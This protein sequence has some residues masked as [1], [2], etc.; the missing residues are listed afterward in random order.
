MWRAEKLFD[1]LYRSIVPTLPV[2]NDAYTEVGQRFNDDQ[3]QWKRKHL[4]DARARKLVAPDKKFRALLICTP[5][6]GMGD[7]IFLKKFVTL[8]S[9]WFPNCILSLMADVQNYDFKDIFDWVHVYD[10]RT[11][12]GDYNESVSLDNAYVHGEH[13]AANDVFFI[14]PHLTMNDFENWRYPPEYHLQVLAPE[15]GVMSH[16]TFWIGEYNESGVEIETGFGTEC[17][18]FLDVPPSDESSLPKV[19]EGQSFVLAYVTPDIGDEPKTVRSILTFIMAAIEDKSELTVIMPN[20]AVRVVAKV[21]N[22]DYE[23]GVSE[24][25]INTDQHVVL[26]GDVL[27]V[28]YT[29]MIQMMRQSD[30]YVMVTGDQSLSDVIGCCLGKKSIWY[31]WLPWKEEVF[32]AVVEDHSQYVTRG[33][34]KVKTFKPKDI[35]FREKGKAVILSA[36]S[37]ALYPSEEMQTESKLLFQKHVVAANAIEPVNIIR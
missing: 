2:L 29:Q 13:V 3:S 23:L 8:L 7:V 18:V 12:H 4:F 30:G 15:A 5:L 33:T 22:R 11:K 24:F 32:E 10:L 37:M 34:A 9:E 6:G 21:L 16:N 1:L 14:L 17:G 26:R 25:T 31:Q 35:D 36:I 27:P 20:D 28:P 19:L